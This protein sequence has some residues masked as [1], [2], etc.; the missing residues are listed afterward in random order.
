[1][2]VQCADREH[3]IA[4]VAALSDPVRRALYDYVVAQGREVGRHEAAGALGISRALAAFHLDKLVEEGLLETTYLRLTG[5]TGPGA[6]RPS[7]LY[8]RSRQ[9]IDLTLPPRSYEVAARLFAESLADESSSDIRAR[10]HD[11]AYSSGVRLG[12][13]AS[14]TAHGPS[15]QPDL[16]ESGMETL[17]QHGYEPYEA[18][19]GEVRLRNCPFHELS[20]DYRQLVCGTNLCLMRGFATGLGLRD[21]DVAL[22]PRPGE[23]CVVFRTKGMLGPNPQRAHDPCHA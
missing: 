12:E 2:D 1:M 8:R 7:K 4:G 14:Q 10:L 22:D 11:V 18:D 20:E 17:Q 9:R 5:R 13:Q 23:C 6:G 16:L 19:D 21:M 3:Q 15:D